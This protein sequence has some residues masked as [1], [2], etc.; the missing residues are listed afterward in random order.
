MD[1]STLLNTGSSNAAKTSDAA[2]KAQENQDRFLTLLVAQMKNQD[3]MNPMENAQLTSQ[4]AQIQTVT[5]IDQLNTSIEKMG[6]QFSQNASMQGVAMI[7]R[8][9]TLSGNRMQM[10]NDGAV[11]TFSL[12][13]AADNV[14]VEVT[15]AAGTVIDTVQLGAATSG[16]HSFS[17]TREGYSPDQELHFRVKATRG[18]TAVASETFSRDRVV[19]VNTDGAKLGFVLA[20]GNTTTFDD[21]LSVD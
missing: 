4:I 6:A 13:G 16:R 14:T 20:S 15:T 5:G 19:A 9:V 21:I 3:P 7:G 8:D 17:W 2:K 1:V 11:G 10:G 12:S 18:A